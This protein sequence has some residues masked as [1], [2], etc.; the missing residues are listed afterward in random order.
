MA[1]AK[2]TK[3]EKD[4]FLVQRAL[5]GEQS[6][7]NKIFT[8]YRSV[9]VYQI[10][11]IVSEEDIVEDIMMETFEKAFE[12]FPKFQ[13]DYQLGAWLTRI[14]VNCAI[15]H[16]R[17]KARVSITSISENEDDD[18][19]PTLQIM[20]SGYTPEEMLA[21]NQRIKFIKDSMQALPK[22]LRKVIQLRYFDE[23][24]YDEIAEEMGC[25]IRKIKSYLHKAKDELIEIVHKR[26][27]KDILKHNI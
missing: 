6:A 27:P 25:E 26:A 9:L 7:Y 18:D 16:T 8:K 12:R 1:T 22:H 11:N 17:K 10:A 19:R 24:S 21:K 15:D 20:D 23:C 13:P 5:C 2:L 14:A 3:K 4:F